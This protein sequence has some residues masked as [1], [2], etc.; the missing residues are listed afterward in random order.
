M[1]WSLAAV[2]PSPHPI[3]D[4]I[5]SHLSVRDL[6]E[7]FLFTPISHP[8]LKPLKNAPRNAPNS[9]HLFTRPS[10]SNRA[11]PRKSNDS[12]GSIQLRTISHGKSLKLMLQPMI[13]PMPRDPKNIGVRTDIRPRGVLLADFPRKQP[14]FSRVIYL[15]HLVLLFHN[16]WR[17]LTGERLPLRQR[18]R[19]RRSGRMFGMIFYKRIF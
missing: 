13:S 8:L 15:L 3:S 9:T 16:M 2:L 12:K 6:A 7:R 14:H 5:T 17:R 19:L 11:Y 4:L 10:I 1:Q 18:H